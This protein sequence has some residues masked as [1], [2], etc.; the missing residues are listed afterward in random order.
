MSWQPQNTDTGAT[1]VATAEGGSPLRPRWAAHWH[2][3]LVL[4][5]FKVGLKSGAD[6]SHLFPVPK[7]LDDRLAPDTVHH[8]PQFTWQWGST[9]CFPAYHPSFIQSTNTE[10]PPTKCLHSSRLWERGREGDKGPAHV[11]M[12]LGQGSQTANK[13][14][15]NTFQHWGLPWGSEASGGSGCRFKEG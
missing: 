7:F 9:S 2:S 11:G 4:S 3:S 1:M 14:T 8:Q 12:T 15:S 13:Q 10:Q 5:A 6:T